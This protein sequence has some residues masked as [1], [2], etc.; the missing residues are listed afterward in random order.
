GKPCQCVY[1]LAKEKLK[2]IG[3][4]KVSQERVSRLGKTTSGTRG[5]SHLLHSLHADLG[6]HGQGRLHVR[7][8]RRNRY[9]A[10]KAGSWRIAST[11]RTEHL[12]TH[13]RWKAAPECK[14]QLGRPLNANLP[15]EQ[16]PHEIGFLAQETQPGL[17]IG[18][19]SQ[20]GFSIVAFA[21]L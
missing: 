2:S 19:K 5:K 13:S 20:I 8:P 10:A 14:Q 17:G 4:D 6:Q 12:C 9:S 1:Q 21:N 16:R 7:S 18:S 11:T 15:A 3:A